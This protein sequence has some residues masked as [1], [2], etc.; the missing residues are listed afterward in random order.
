[1][2]NGKP[3]SYVES[4]EPPLGSEHAFPHMHY[5]SGMID[6]K[7]GL[8]KREWFAA[9]ALQGLLSNPDVKPK[10]EANEIDLQRVSEVNASYATVAVSLAD[11]LLKELKS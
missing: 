7:G 8:S 2:D 3:H 11:A 6:L 10:Y 9:M 1:M 5:S 4:K